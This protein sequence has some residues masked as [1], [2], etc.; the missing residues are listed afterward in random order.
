MPDSDP[1]GAVFANAVPLE[2]SSQHQTVFQGLNEEVDW[3]GKK[4][5][6][7]LENFRG[8]EPDWAKAKMVYADRHP[9][10]FRMLLDPVGAMKAVNGRVVGYAKDLT[11]KE[12]GQPRLEGTSIFTDPEV[13]DLYSQGHL[14]L[15]TSFIAFLDG[16][17]TSIK[18]RVHPN[19]IY[20]FDRRKTKPRDRMAMFL[21]SEDSMAEN[22]EVKGLFAKILEMLEALGKPPAPAPAGIANTST[23]DD[24]RE[25]K[26]KEQITALENALADA[27][28]QV[29]TLKTENK[30]LKDTVV[31]FEN[32]QKEA[33]KEAAWT[34]IK[35][36]LPVGMLNT[37]EMA[38]STRKMFEEQPEAFANAI[39]DLKFKAGTKDQGG[40]FNNS[41]DE[42]AA[43]LADLKAASGR[44]R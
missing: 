13:E 34:T 25:L 21:N 3:N 10:P 18:G 12:T 33:A 16:E 39:L 17:G 27:K 28:T 41:E 30:T 1:Q 32:A 35:A 43:A 24:T 38:A 36:K 6:Y 22:D 5:R 40:E 14:S 26:M 20:V 19:H 11:V 29:E 23:G 2:P 7:G 15:S 37:D 8:T 4:V 42:D 9:D 31:G 44:T